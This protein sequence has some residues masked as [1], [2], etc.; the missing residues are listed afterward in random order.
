MPSHATTPFCTSSLAIDN[1]LFAPSQMYYRVPR[2]QLSDS[3]SWIQW[4]EEQNTKAI[5][6]TFIVPSEFQT[7]A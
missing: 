5:V 6:H 3:Y 2:A 4:I 1:T 7:K